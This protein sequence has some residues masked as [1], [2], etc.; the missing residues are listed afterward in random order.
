VREALLADPVTGFAASAIAFPAFV[1][2]EAATAARTQE[3]G[4]DIFR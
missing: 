2:A 4:Y 1:V 3:I